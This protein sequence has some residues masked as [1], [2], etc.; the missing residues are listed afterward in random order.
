MSCLLCANIYDVDKKEQRTKYWALS[1]PYLISIFAHLMSKIPSNRYILSRYDWTM[2]VALQVFHD[3][4]VWEPIKDLFDFQFLTLSSQLD[5]WQCPCFENRI[6]L[7][8]ESDWPSQ[9]LQYSHSPGRKCCS[10][11]T[12][13]SPCCWLYCI[14]TL[15]VEGASVAQSSRHSTLRT[16]STPGGHHSQLQIPIQY[17]HPTLTLNM[18]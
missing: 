15:H 16:C 18:A 6:S 13:D 17:I 3:N 2:G 12:R 7:T 8:S 1:T 9:R 11:W 10:C 4:L 5:K 14:G